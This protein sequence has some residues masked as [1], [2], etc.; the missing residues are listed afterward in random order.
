MPK[1]TKTYNLNLH[2]AV[3]NIVF[4][5]AAG[6][7]AMTFDDLFTAAIVYRFFLGAPMTKQERDLVY[8]VLRKYDE[9]WEVM[10]HEGIS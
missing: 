4:G 8:D 3:F 7:F 1:I 9:G 5:N 2:H 10:K 6:L